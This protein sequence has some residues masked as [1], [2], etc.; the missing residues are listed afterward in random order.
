MGARAGER[1][2]VGSGWGYAGGWEASVCFG[3]AAGARGRDR[4]RVGG[5]ARQGWGAGERVFRGHSDWVWGGARVYGAGG[6]AE[7]AG[8][9]QK[10]DRGVG[11]AETPEQRRLWNWLL[12]VGAVFG[13]LL[14]GRQ[15]FDY[16]ADAGRAE[17][18]RN[19]LFSALASVGMLFIVG[20]IAARRE[21][22]RRQVSAVSSSGRGRGAKRS[23]ARRKGRQ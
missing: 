14:L 12:G 9:K 21:Q 22:V 23:A 7:A 20:L 5:G 4:S 19:D 8:L 1:F 11:S 17:V 6:L 16:F 13:V 3:G 18:Q 10:A 15:I 2:W